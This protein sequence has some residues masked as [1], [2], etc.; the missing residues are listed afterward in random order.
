MSWNVIDEKKN[1][2]LIYKITKNY[3]NMMEFYL[4]IL[5]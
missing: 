4:H 5:I 2:H 1:N 3:Q